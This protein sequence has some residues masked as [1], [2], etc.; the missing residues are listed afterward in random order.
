MVRFQSDYSEVTSVEEF[1]ILL[2]PFWMYSADGYAYWV[3]FLKNCYETWVL[4]IS[5]LVFY[6]RGEKSSLGSV[7]G[8][9][10]QLVT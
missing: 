4:E 8:V 9:K 5:L 1:D 10:A 6:E 3:I 7:R 2:K